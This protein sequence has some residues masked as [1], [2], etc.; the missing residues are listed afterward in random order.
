MWWQ[1]EPTQYAASLLRLL[2]RN[3]QRKSWTD[4]AGSYGDLHSRSGSFRDHQATQQPASRTSRDDRRS[5]SRR[6][7]D[8]GPSGIRNPGIREPRRPGS[9]YYDYNR[10]VPPVA[11]GYDDRHHIA[12][13]ARPVYP[14]GRPTSAYRLP[15]RIEG[16]HLGSRDYGA[17]YE[18]PSAL[19]EARAP[20][21]DR[22]M[23]S[24]SYY[25]RSDSYHAPQPSTHG[26]AP[27][28]VYPLAAR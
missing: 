19:Y 7:D 6:Q 11:H 5:S 4:R 12:A 16:T 25:R 3:R 27:Y 9:P 14:V 26:G 23:G 15:Q 21:G 20:H 10:Q 8:H 24:G 22:H 13:S 18:R 17:G 2:P 28:S 1:C